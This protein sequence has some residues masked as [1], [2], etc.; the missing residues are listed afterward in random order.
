MSDSSV[1]IPDELLQRAATLTPDNRSEAVRVALTFGLDALEKKSA[2]KEPPTA[3]PFL[4]SG[5][6]PGPP[7]VFA[8]AANEPMEIAVP[9]CPWLAYEPI[10]IRLHC[11]DPKAKVEVT[12]LCSDDGQGRNLLMPGW[13]GRHSFNG[14]GTALGK[15]ECIRSPNN[16]T[17]MVRS[18]RPTWVAV[19]L[20]V[21]P[22]DSYFEGSFFFEKARPAKGTTHNRLVRVPFE[23][24]SERSFATIARTKPVNWGLLRIVRLVFE[25]DPAL[26]YTVFEDFKIGAGANLAMAEDWNSAADYTEKWGAGFRAY[27]ILKSPNFAEIALKHVIQGEEPVLP[28]MLAEVIEDTQA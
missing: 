11:A 10:N 4:P 2:L 16:V 8:L 3:L 13:H 27:P 21:R 26:L 7:S 22:V 18:D 9:Q 17:L 14:I 20:V 23:V 24:H 1:R 19:T 6:E 12:R 25:P 5:E 15:Y 28:L